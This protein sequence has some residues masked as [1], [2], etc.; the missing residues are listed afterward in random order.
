MARPAADERIDRPTAVQPGVDT[1]VVEPAEHLD[2]VVFVE[3]PAMRVEQRTPRVLAAQPDV[4]ERDPTGIERGHHLDCIDRV[5]GPDVGAL[6]QQL[7]FGRQVPDAVSIE[8]GSPPRTT[9]RRIAPVHPR[10]IVTVADGHVE[11][12]VAAGPA[13]PHVVLVLS[14][15]QRTAAPRAQGA[16]GRHHRLPPSCDQVAQHLLGIAASDA[17]VD[18]VVRA[19]RSPQV[20]LERVPAGDPPGRWARRQQLAHL[21]QGQRCPRPERLVCHGAERRDASADRRDGEFPPDADPQVRHHVRGH[22]GR[23]RPAHGPRGPRGGCS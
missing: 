18:V 15:R 10:G 2:D 6:E 23:G 7:Q 16:G 9:K 5:L 1:G 21:A 8:H 13:A 12:P 17:D 4:E 20:Q 11:L 19:P 14:S 3:R 22:T